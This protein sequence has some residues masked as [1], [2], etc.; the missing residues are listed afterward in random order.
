MRTEPSAATTTAAHGRFLFLDGLRGIAALAVAWFHFYRWTPLYPTLHAVL[1]APVGVALGQGYLGVDI[2]F[3]LS[4]FVISYSIRNA[5]ITPGFVGRFALR[6]SLRLDPPYWVTIALALALAALAQLFLPGAPPLPSWRVV[7][8]HLFYLQ[9]ILGYHNIVSV[10][11]TLCLEVQFYLLLVLLVGVAQ[12]LVR[13]AKSGASRGWRY[14]LLFAPLYV[15]SLASLPAGFWTDRWFIGFWYAFFFGAVTYWTLAGRLQL[16]WW[17]LAAA[18][19][20]GLCLTF[21]DPQAPAALVTATLIL[22][23]GRTGKLYRWLSARPL[24]FLGRISY[25]LYLLHFVGGIVA[26]LG[27]RMLG[28]SPATVLSLFAAA[29]AVSIMSAE[30]MHRLVEVPSMR[31]ARSDRFP[32]L[33]AGIRARF[34]RGE[35]AVSSLAE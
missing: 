22:I 2:F 18:G 19:V 33:L 26:R 11:W 21:P 30:V 35:D 13:G 15:A 1:P 27:T 12:R 24:Q 8:A 3:V 34:A 5:T 29:T 10:F 6:R 4:G 17:L 31:L 9:G 16:R 23:A 14:A 32:E 25:S 20:L 28:S 7:V